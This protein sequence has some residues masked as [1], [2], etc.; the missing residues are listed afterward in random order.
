M[1]SRLR[2]SGTGA[3]PGA[4]TGGLP[5]MRW[6]PGSK[7]SMLGNYLRASPAERKVDNAGPPGNGYRGLLESYHAYLDQLRVHDWGALGKLFVFP[8][9]AFGY[10]WT[11]SNHVAGAKLAQRI[12][13]IIEESRKVT[14]LCEKVILVTHSMGGLVARSAMT[15]AGAEGQ[16]LGVVHGVQPAYGA[17][18]AYTRI[19]GGF[20]GGF[21]DP[22]SRC[23]GPTGRDVTAL[24]AN[25]VGGLQLLPGRQY[26][27]SKGSTQWLK[28]PA[29]GAGPQL[30]P[31]GN[32]P[33]NDIYRV[34]AIVG[35]DDGKGATYNTYWGIVDPAL[36]TPEV[37]AAKPKPGSMDEDMAGARTNDVAWKGYLAN[38]ADAES[39]LTDLGTYRRSAWSSRTASSAS[40]AS[41]PGSP[42]AGPP[43]AQPRA[44][45]SRPRPCKRAPPTSTSCG[46]P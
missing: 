1:G 30:L 5:N 18:A 16:V 10:N 23:L 45:A 2:L 35:P 38:L 26:Q 21:W 4:K 40:T 33:F 11:A 17:V 7:S 3:T 6:D 13:E 27:T 19:K 44:S 29:P 24:L 9:H 37:V 36:L 8:V 32:D 14:G 41:T 42:R 34:P 39:L 12:G 15:L 28:V 46:M 25:S 31:L 20:E 43:T 22:T